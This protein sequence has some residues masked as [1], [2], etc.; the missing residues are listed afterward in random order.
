MYSNI[1]KIIAIS[2]FRLTPVHP[3][4][5]WD[6]GAYFTCGSCLWCPAWRAIFQLPTV[7]VSSHSPSI[8]VTLVLTAQRDRDQCE[9]LSSAGTDDQR[10][11]RRNNLEMFYICAFLKKKKKN[12]DW[13]PIVVVCC[14]RLS[15]R[16]VFLSLL[17]THKLL[18]DVEQQ[19]WQCS[20]LQLLCCCLRA[21]Y[22]DDCCLY[23]V[24]IVT[25]V[26]IKCAIVTTH[27]YL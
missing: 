13:W 21:A 11:S 16:Q 26:T 20:F 5:W 2:R 19:N 15:Y 1:N 10:D 14:C 24:W 12:T 9:V 4:V 22:N 23:K 25:I 17:C 18:C 6:G 7:C 3:S 27:L 8:R